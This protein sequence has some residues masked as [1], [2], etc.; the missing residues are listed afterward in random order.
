MNNS[1]SLT[2]YS[3]GNIELKNRIVMAPM[4]RSR[5]INN[6]PNELIAEYYGQRATAGLIIT[7]GT[8]P[9]PNGLGYARIPGIFSVEQIN[10]WKKV[11]SAVHNNGGKIFVQLMHTG[12]VA[13]SH[14]LPFGARVLAPSAIAAPGEMWTDQEGMQHHATPVAM[15][16]AHLAETKREFVQAAK[17]AMY[18]GFDGIELHA[19]NGYLLEQ[20]LSSNANQRTDNY[21]GSIENRARFVLEVVQEVSEAIGKE[22]TAIRLSPF[23]MYND[24]QHHDNEALFSY[25]AEELN[26]IGIVYVHIT[27]QATGSKPD[28]KNLV[29]KSIRNKFNNTIIL[30]GG[31]TLES[32]EEA[33]TEDLGD[34]VSFG[35]PFISNP[36]LVSR[37]HKNLPLNIKLDANTLYSADS[38]GYTD[39]PV[40]EEELISA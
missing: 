13:H 5:A 8:S 30:S 33:I 40:F 23:A 16:D 29:R 6:V 18:A 39:Y 38:K 36:D 22:K 25:L 27:D 28:V 37:F 1:T 14:N 19:A 31:Y 4:T 15:T 24:I 35:R 12:R 2:P 7:E 9:S 21:G 17:N 10:G 11:T 3:L 32:A 34:L 26:K 20:F